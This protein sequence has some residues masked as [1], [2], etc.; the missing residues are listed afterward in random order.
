LT[1]KIWDDYLVCMDEGLTV[2]FKQLE[3]LLAQVAP[4][5]PGGA[6]QVVAEWIM[7]GGMK[8]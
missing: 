3:R 2:D 1:A 5:T 6:R 7:P 4:A 8:D